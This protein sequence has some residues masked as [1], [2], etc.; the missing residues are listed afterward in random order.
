M[1][2]HEDIFNNLMNNNWPP[3]ASNQFVDDVLFSALLE[4]VEADETVVSQVWGVRLSE[5]G[6]LTSQYELL[7]LT[8]KRLIS[9][10]SDIDNDK[11]KIKVFSQPLVNVYKF[12]A[13]PSNLH[14]GYIR[15]NIILKGTAWALETNDLKTADHFNKSLDRLLI[16]ARQDSEATVMTNLLN[17]DKSNKS[18]K[19]VHADSLKDSKKAKKV[20]KTNK[21]NLEKLKSYA[22]TN[23]LWF[24]IALGS[25]FSLLIIGAM[26]L[27]SYNEGTASNTMRLVAGVFGIIFGISATVAFLMLTMKVWDKDKFSRNFYRVLWETTLSV[28]TIAFGALMVAVPGGATGQFGAAFMIVASLYLTFDSAYMLTKRTNDLKQAR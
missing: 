22:R 11:D 17:D 19:T 6:E 25:T 26:F 21:H 18:L 24:S 8:S 12:S 3:Y 23:I 20:T 9:V 27:G 10:Y 2:K 14:K 28:A 15:I 1:K 16:K 13:Q 5:Q 7:T 4:Q